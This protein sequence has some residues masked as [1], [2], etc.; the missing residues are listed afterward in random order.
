MIKT[1]TVILPKEPQLMIQDPAG[2]TK[3]GNRGCHRLHL[4][5]EGSLSLAGVDSASMAAKSVGEL[6]CPSHPQ[7]SSMGD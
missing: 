1:P 6:T 2:I 3:V 5:V 4:F 7:L